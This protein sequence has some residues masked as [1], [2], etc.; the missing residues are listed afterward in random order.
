[1]HTPNGSGGV[2]PP[3]PKP[4]RVIP[5]GLI[6]QGYSPDTTEAE[7]REKFEKKYGHAPHEVYINKVL[8]WA[9]PVIM[10]GRLAVVTSVTLSQLN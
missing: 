10:P 4:P 2:N 7:A 5:L 9:G 8:V 1:M 3:H 6:Y